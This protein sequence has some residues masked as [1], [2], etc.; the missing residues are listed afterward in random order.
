M[1]ILIDDSLASAPLV[2]AIR[3][4]FAALDIETVLQP[5]LIASGVSASDAALLPSGEYGALI[6]THA[7]ETALAIVFDKLGPVALRTP[8]RP[9]AV[10]QTPIKLVDASSSAELLA[11]ATLD[12]F[13][14]ITPAG[15][16]REDAPDAQAVVAEGVQAVTPP[17]AGFSEDLAKAWYVLTSEP[18]VSHILVSPISIDADSRAQLLA[19]VASLVETAVEQRRAVRNR[20]VEATGA[21]REALTTLF[22]ATR[23]SLEESDRRALLMLLQLGNRRGEVGPY[24]SGLKF[25]G[26]E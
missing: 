19:A 2:E 7:I 3:G 14:G 11:R 20:I 5:A 15:F 9:D 23:W 12:P 21:D 24:V 10:E 6:E 4:G 1:R 26:E 16:L 18:Y 25:A 17:E 8:V 22:K 13:F